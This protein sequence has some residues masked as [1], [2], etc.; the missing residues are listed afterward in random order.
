[1]LNSLGVIAHEYSVESPPT[2]T[3]AVS[4]TESSTY[5]NAGDPTK[6]DDCRFQDSTLRS[7]TTV[8]M[9]NLLTEADPAVADSQGNTPLCLA[10]QAGN[11]VQAQQLIRRGAD[12]QHINLDGDNALTLAAAGGHLTFIEWL[13]SHYPQPV[14][15]ENY[16]AE[17][18]LTLAARH[19]HQPLVQW[20]VSRGA[21]VVHLNDQLKD[22]LA[23]AVANGH[24]ALAIWLASQGTDLRQ[25]YPD[26]N[27]LFLHAVCAGHQDIAQWLEDSGV[28]SQQINESGDSAITLAARHGHHQLLARLLAKNAAGTRKICRNGDSPLLIAARHGHGETVKLLVQHGADIG[29]VNYAGSSVLTLAATSDESLALWL[30]DAGT[31]IHHID[32]S[33]NNAFTL[34]AQSGFFQLMQTLEQL[35]INIHQIN[36]DN[37]NAFTLVAGQGSLSWCQWLAGKGIN[38]HQVNCQHHNA[39]TLAAVAGSLPLLQWLCTEG[40]DWQQIPRALSPNNDFVE[41]MDYGF[42]AAILAACAGHFIEAQWLIRQGLSIHQR[43]YSGRNAVIMAVQQGQLGAVQWFTEQGILPDGLPDK[44]PEYFIRYQ[45]NTMN[46]AARFG[47][48]PVMQW[49]HQNGGS[50]DVDE[51]DELL[52]LLAARRGDLPMSQWLW[53]QGADMGQFYLMGSSAL[54]EAVC[55]GHLRLSQW[56]ISHR[57]EDMPDI[58]DNFALTLAAQHGHNAIFRWLPGSESLDN[59]QANEMLLHALDHGHRSLAVWLCLKVCKSIHGVDYENKNALMLAAKHGFLWLTQWLS[60]HTPDINQA[61]RRGDTAVM[62]A[63]ANGHLPVVQWLYLE[64]NAD[65]HR[66]ENYDSDALHLAVINSQTETANWLIDQGMV[67]DPDY[68]RVRHAP[69]DSRVSF[70]ITPPQ[71][72]SNRNNV[73]LLQLLLRQQLPDKF[74]VDHML[75]AIRNGDV[76]VLA[77]CLSAGMSLND[78]DNSCFKAA[79]AGGSLATLEYL[80]HS[81][82]N[83]EVDSARKSSLHSA[84]LCGNLHIIQWFWVRSG[85][86][87]DEKN[88]CLLTASARGHSHVVKWLYSQGA[89]IGK[90]NSQGYSSLLTAVRRGNLPMLEWFYQQGGDI[91]QTDVD[92]NGALSL[93]IDFPQ[94]QAAIWLFQRGCRLTRGDIDRPHGP[95]RLASMIFKLTPEIRRA[96]L[97]H[98]CSLDAKRWLLRGLQLCSMNENPSEEEAD[99]SFA[100]FNQYND[101][102]LEHKCLVAVAKLIEQQ[103]GTLKASLKVVDSLPISA[104]CKYNLRELVGIDLKK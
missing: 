20:L 71:W 73:G 26:G 34:A 10:A 64:K 44:I 72:D 74:R 63:A 91:Y 25:V 58:D 24:L 57:A 59:Q 62:L 17:T 14:N 18:A 98:S 12:V 35:G 42:N 6:N 41:F 51:D 93:A 48:L 95:S 70:V 99:A 84:A 9:P 83:Y 19:G 101:K 79:A 21:S 37:D 81:G 8:Q 23:E 50:L 32:L 85:L 13:D 56:L 28:N 54:S 1:M 68:F 4:P 86:S 31:D 5:L 16:Y 7:V 2:E 104:V 77:C 29:Q 66:K 96:S 76:A 102:T 61:S 49:L 38:I 67:L 69:W 3:D 53:R 89:D 78:D 90:K 43:D 15:H 75:D 97:F 60:E 11:L 30:C 33:G 82:G 47:H 39:V 45:Y 22:A 36:H 100:R 88:C 92:G 94:P 87:K 52:M 27:N 80:C 103:S 55:H 65:P 46:L 40:V